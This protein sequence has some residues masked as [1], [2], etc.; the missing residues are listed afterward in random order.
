MPEPL[1]PFVPYRPLP[2]VIEAYYIYGLN[3][4]AFKTF[5]LCDSTSANKEAL[6]SVEINTGLIPRKPLGMK[7][8]LILHNGPSHKDS[9]LSATCPESVW[10]ATWL[11]FNTNSLIMLPPVHPTPNA[12]KKDM[13]K[14]K[15]VAE[16]I[17]GGEGVSFRISLV[18]GKAGEE[19][20]E[21]FEWSVSI[22]IT[23]H[24]LTK[25]TN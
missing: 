22:F 10:S 4:V 17:A 24:L 7:P 2:P 12:T 19:R 9:I 8:G 25:H 16:T 1:R 3:V 15:M 18:I 21:A 20:I 13:V 11:A 5:K 23:I 14:E 6:F